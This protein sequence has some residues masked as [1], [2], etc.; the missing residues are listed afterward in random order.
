VVATRKDPAWK[1]L[2]LLIVKPVFSGRERTRAGYVRGRSIRQRGGW[3]RVDHGCREA[4]LRLC[5]RMA[6]KDRPVDTAIVGIVDE[7]H[8]D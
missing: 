5:G 2:K 4:P 6:C 7:V 8:L 1:A 3:E